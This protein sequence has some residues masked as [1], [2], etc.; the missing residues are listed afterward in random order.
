MIQEKDK[1]KFMKKCRDI[2]ADIENNSLKFDP[3][4]MSG[5]LEGPQ[6]CES[7]YNLRN[8]LKD[9]KKAEITD[10]FRYSYLLSI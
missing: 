2:Y 8:A 7:I 1:V 6:L 3:F 4:D 9:H 10:V 5:R